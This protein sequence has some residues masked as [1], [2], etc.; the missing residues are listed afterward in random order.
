MSKD[1]VSPYKMNLPTNLKNRLQEAA[2]RSGRSL[3]SE[4]ITRLEA[5]IEMTDDGGLDFTLSSFERYIREVVENSV[6]DLRESVLT[7]ERFAAGRDPY[8]EER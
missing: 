7:L 1:S 3:S 5:S 4:I 2:D 6:E 8:N